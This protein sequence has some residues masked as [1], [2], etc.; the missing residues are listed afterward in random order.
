MDP[1]ADPL[2]TLPATRFVARPDEAPRRPRRWPSWAALALCALMAAC[3]GGG[4]ADAPPLSGDPGVDAGTG[5][6]GAAPVLPPDPA[7]SAPAQPA[8]LPVLAID[9]VNQAPIVSREDYLDGSFRLSDADG[10]TLAESTLEIRGRG[11][12]TWNYPKKPYRVRLTGGEP[13]LGMP[14]SRH[15]VL[16]ANY[17]DKTMLRN[18]I[19]FEISRVLG[20]AYTP[21]SRF[22][23]VTLNGAYAGVYQ[24]TESI[25]VGPDRVDIPALDE[26]DTSA[27]VITGGYLLEVDQRRGEDFCFDSK[28][29]DM[30]FCAADPEELLDAARQPQRDYI[31]GY[32]D[33]LDAALFGPDF[34]DPAK[35]YAAYLDVDSAVAYFLI[36]ELVKNVDGNLRFSTYLYKKRDGK[37]F[38]GPVWDFDRS[39]G[40]VNYAGADRTDGWRTRPTPWYTRLFQDP[41][42]AAKVR[43]RWAQ[44]KADGE[45]DAILAYI[46]ERAFYLS[47]AQ[48]ANF[49][50]WPILDQELDITRVIPGSY[51]G[52]IAVMK[53]WLQ[54][55]IAW[56]DT[57][58]GQ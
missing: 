25:R 55:R 34:R 18:D 48:K 51:E 19:A 40:N 44:M 43:A 24:L 5:D 38:F 20:M 53:E 22:V 58:L 49:V 28:R 35:G 8:R 27:D 12:T 10:Q 47:E 11:N 21:R 4:S 26:T 29:T 54:A 13:L 9:T 32:I 33:A 23:D 46:D 41:A 3:G 57:Q 16:L 30:V 50:R 14:S 37:L 52:E 36:Q 31:V 56:M 6:P 17:A 15:W 2:C 7:A 39:L 1:N 45:L 42:F